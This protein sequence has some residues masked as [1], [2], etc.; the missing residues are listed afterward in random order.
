MPLA[1]NAVA[2]NTEHPQQVQQ[3]LG[4]RRVLSMVT[5]LHQAFTGSIQSTAGLIQQQEA[6]VAGQGS[7]DAHALLLAPAEGN[8]A[9]ISQLHGQSLVRH[10]SSPML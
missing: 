5:H 3:W 7:C 1:V 8:A 4:V 10:A 6:G 2:P 9:S